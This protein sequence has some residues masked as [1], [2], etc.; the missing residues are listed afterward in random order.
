MSRRRTA[1]RCSPNE[2]APLDYSQ[3]KD[4]FGIKIVKEGADLKKMLP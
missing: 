3:A 2:P 4:E 1:P